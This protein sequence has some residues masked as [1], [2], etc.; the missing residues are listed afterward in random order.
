MLRRRRQV[1]GPFSTCSI[2]NPFVHRHICEGKHKGR[3]FWAKINRVW[4]AL[5]TDQD[6]HPPLM[7]YLKITERLLFPL[8]GPFSLTVSSVIRH[9]L[10][11]KPSLCWLF[12]NAPPLSIPKHLVSLSCSLFFH[13]PCPCPRTT[14]FTY[15]LPV[16]HQCYAGACSSS[17]AKADCGI[18]R[19]FASRWL[20][21]PS[22]AYLHHG[23][24]HML[25][26][27]DFFFSAL[28]YQHTT[29]HHQMRAR[30]ENRICLIPCCVLSN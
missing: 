22:W 8:P 7:C 29:A 18:F 5:Y 4:A 28:A 27:G 1:K 16:P 10:P 24:W 11:V 21:W 25:Q 12:I 19:N 23:N 3:W 14:R 6:G 13:N 30:W 26:I 9:C 17:F 20:N 2:P 15:L